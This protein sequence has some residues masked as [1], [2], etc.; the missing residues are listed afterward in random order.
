MGYALMFME[1]AACGAI[2]CPH[3]NKAPSIR[4]NDQGQPD[5]NGLRRPICEDCFNKWNQ[6][7]RINKGLEPIPLKP[8]AYGPCEE[9]EI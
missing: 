4:L 3:P 6:H 2:C 5:P 7:H 1:C 9:N 8:G